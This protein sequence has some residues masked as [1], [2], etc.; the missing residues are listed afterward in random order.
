[1]YPGIFIPKSANGRLVGSLFFGRRKYFWPKKQHKKQC[2]PEGMID[3]TDAVITEYAGTRRGSPARTY[4][5]NPQGVRVLDGRQRLRRLYRFDPATNIMTER[6]IA[7]NDKIVRRCIFDNMGMLEETFSFGRPPRTYRYEDGCRRIVMREGGDYGAVSRTYSFEQNGVSETGFGRDGATGR[8]FTID[9]GNNAIIERTGGWYGDISRTIVF[10][11]IDPSLFM[12][13]ESFLQ[14]LMFTDMSDEEREADVQ[15][16]VAKIR[17]EAQQPGVYRSK[18]AFT[19]VRH[20]PRD[21]PA[22]AGA[23]VTSGMR[24]SGSPQSRSRDGDTSLD[25]IGG[26]DPGVEDARA[27]PPEKSLR[28]ADIPFEER[29]QAAKRDEGKK[30]SKGRSAEISYDERRSGRSL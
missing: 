12:E 2:I 8:V 1:M 7:H 21:E 20:T 29:L 15:E 23:R 13:P 5:Y 22:D 16:Q 17:G 6:D 24:P 30:L 18:Y 28:S 14:F 3:M 26:D 27:A 19:G 9:P 25:F 10:E 4:L 11:R